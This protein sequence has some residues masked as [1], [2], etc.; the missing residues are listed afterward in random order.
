MYSKQIRQSAAPPATILNDLLQLSAGFY[1][2]MIPHE[3][4]KVVCTM[5]EGELVDPE[6]NTCTRCEGSGL[7]PKMYRRAVPV[8]CPK[9]QLLFDLM[10]ECE[11]SGRIVIFAS[12]QGAIDRIKEL[13]ESTKSE[14]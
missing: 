8:E 12:F 2:K 6:G 9:E 14:S 4:E 13:V 3:T 7:S 11:E 10:E 1:Y 5:C